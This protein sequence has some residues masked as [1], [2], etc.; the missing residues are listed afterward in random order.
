[1]MLP[2]LPRDNL[3]LSILGKGGSI[4]DYKQFYLSAQGRVN[5]K[6]LWL[7]L[8]LPAVV[9][10][11]ILSLIDAAIGTVD[12][13]SGLGLLS[14]LWSLIILI[15]AI[16]IYIKRFHDRDKS[17]WWVL[18]GLIPIIG[19]L[20]LLIELGFLKGTD[21]PNRYGPPVTD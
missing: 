3:A 18:I 19:A 11:L 5:R 9:V 20:W 14:G 16:L 13:E 10:S 2:V 8:V 12:A 15:P 6:Q 21:G 17:G 7:Y 1:M 4:M